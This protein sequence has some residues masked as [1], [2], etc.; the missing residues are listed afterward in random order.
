MYANHEILRARYSFERSGGELAQTARSFRQS[1]RHAEQEHLAISKQLKL[2]P[3][4]LSRI[5][6]TIEW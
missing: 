6:R 3:V 5:C 1:L 2:T 4:P